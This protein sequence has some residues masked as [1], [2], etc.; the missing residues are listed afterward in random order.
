MS[1]LPSRVPATTARCA[2]LSPAGPTSAV[3]VP[4]SFVANVL[5][6]ILIALVTYHL[7]D[8]AG[9]GFI[10]GAAGL[11]LFAAALAL[12]FAADA[13]VGRLLPPRWRT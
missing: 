1:S 10:H 13:A 7:G 12:I 6:V 8:A 9:Q 2:P 4:V 11:V 3:T 5:R